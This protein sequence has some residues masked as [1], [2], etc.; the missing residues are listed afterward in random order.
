MKIAFVADVHIGN[1]LQFGGE[2]KSGMNGRCR[3]V[4]DT[5]KR[6]YKTAT[7]N[8]GCE[9]FYVLGDLFD[10]EKPTPQML[11]AV[12]EIFGPDNDDVGVIVGN[13]DQ[14]SYTPKDHALAPLTDHV[15]V[16]ERPVLVIPTA[17]VGLWNVPYEPGP[18]VDWLPGRLKEL[19]RH[20]DQAPRQSRPRTRA[21]L[22][23]LGIQDT[24]TAEYM[25]GHDDA[26][27]AD[28]LHI[29][30]Q[31]HNIHHTFAGNWH[32]AQQWSFEDG[33]AIIQ[34]GTLAPVGF[35]DE[36]VT[37]VGQM[38]VFNTAD[39]SVYTVEI[40]GP[41]FVKARIADDEAWGACLKRVTKKNPTKGTKYLQI[42]THPERY[43]SV[44][45][46]ASKKPGTW[47]GIRV[48]PDT[49][50]SQH[51]AQ[52]TASAAKTAANKDAAVAA[53]VKRMPLDKTVSRE[54][55]EKH[56]RRYLDG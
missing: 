53:F 5:L 30:M 51:K 55:V 11:A 56:C 19:Q 35:R 28:A 10:T 17:G 26:I 54:N 27:S 44:R 1:H 24:R 29:L 16:F 14:H 25:R 42:T 41:R 15:Q 46:D 47:A 3:I 22:I 48:V 40:P 38:A 52:Q 4:V 36:G 8:E 7:Q 2:L 6:A 20:E 49:A 18:A 31:R 39:G 21:L 34:C 37:A 50:E 23:H 13:H 9:G 33:R 45:E 32:K 12:Q 43:R